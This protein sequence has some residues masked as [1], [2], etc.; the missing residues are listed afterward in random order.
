MNRLVLIPW[1]LLASTALAN[2]GDEGHWPQFRGPRASGLGKGATVSE[3]DLATRK[4]VRWRVPLPGLSLSSPVVWGDRIYL[5]NA[6]RKAGEAELRVGLYGSIEPVAD[7]G[8]HLFQV[9]CLDRADGKVLWT[10]TAF[11]GTPKF[12]RHPKGSYAASTPATDG[13]HVVA[14]FGTEGL[15]CY[16][17]AGK[18]L[19]SKHFGDLD[20]GFYMVPSASWGFSASPVIHEGV[21]YVQCDVQKDSFVAALSLADGKELWRTPRAEVPTFGPPT[22]DVRAERKQL[23]CNGW[24]HI[25]GYD[26]ATG[27]EL[28]KL[29]GG[30]DIPVPAPVVGDGLVY[31][32]NAHGRVAPVLAIDVLA[33]GTLKLTPDE[34]PHMRWSDLRRG[35]YMQTPLV[36]GEFLYVC[37]DNGVLTCFDA[38]GGEIVYEERLGDGVSGFTSSAVAADGKLYYASEEGVVY[39]VAEGFEFELLARN[40]LGEECMATPAIAEGTLYYRTRGHMT[41]LGAP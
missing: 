30:G 6:V 3:W 11:E 18:L 36:L 10:E 2:A 23:I 29:E 22:V 34:S 8:E 39:V 26:L 32:T 12:P 13:Q 31:I 28:W 40:E 7:E 37:K 19:W 17:A 33:E 5:T 24:K 9:L 1:V 14:F 15:F 16:D 41:A 21:V 27:K 20:A 38:A 4:N 25:G 35:A